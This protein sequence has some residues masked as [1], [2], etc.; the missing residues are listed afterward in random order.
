M[1]WLSVHIDVLRDYGTIIRDYGSILLGLIGIGLLWWRSHSADRQARSSQVQIDLAHAQMEL[2]RQD[3]LVDR[4]QKS[5]DMLGNA[6]MSSRTGGVY[7]LKRLAVDHPEQYHVQVM[8]LL[9][10]FVRSPPPSTNDQPGGQRE[11]VRAALEVIGYRSE[12]ALKIER[13]A[14]FRVDLSG[15]SLTG[16]RIPNS[17]FDGALFIDADLTGVFALDATFLAANFTRT[18]MT[19]G[20]FTQAIFDRSR[21]HAKMSGSSFINASLR[22]TII[23]GDASHADLIKANLT[24]AMLV[25]TDLTKAALD[26]AVLTRARFETPLNLALAASTSAWDL[27]PERRGAETTASI[28]GLCRVTQDQLDTATA[29]PDGPPIFEIGT[30]DVVTG[31]PL[32][33]KTD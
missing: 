18:T 16:A 17:N 8:E 20:N 27:P 23:R 13:A 5:A 1:T 11:D 22:S 25:G 7:A 21:F 3:S 19:D 12:S 4:Y 9:C 33:W 30:T 31:A 26:H 28:A 10:A 15:A 6:V 32:V 14:R 29:A 24:D 2:A